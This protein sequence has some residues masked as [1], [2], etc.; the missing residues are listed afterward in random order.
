MSK[1]RAVVIQ[2]V[3]SMRAIPEPGSDQVSQAI[4]SDIVTVLETKQGYA[5]V[6]SQD[7]YKGW[8]LEG[9]IQTTA[10]LKQWS[11]PDILKKTARI[12]TPFAD[13]FQYACASSD[14]ITRLVFET[15]VRVPDKHVLNKEKPE[16]S[17]CKVLLAD[18][19]DGYIARSV[20]EP[21]IDHSAERT[22]AQLARIFIGTPYLW[23]GTTPFGFD[24]SGLVQRC[25]SAVGIVLPR[26]AYKQAESPLGKSLSTQEPLQAGDLVFFRGHSDP[27]N[28]G[29]THVGIMLDEARMIHAYGKSGVTIHPLNDVEI[30]QNYTYCGAWRYQPGAS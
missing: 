29:I 9:Q 12:S 21:G 20:L 28:R 27:R 2:N 4:M 18:G 10:Q 19:R 26:D 8:I 3:A 13:V 15:A 23:G 6:Q 17:L 14:L 22:P 1:D 7:D 11:S 5:H 30:R 24:C 25:Y 16:N